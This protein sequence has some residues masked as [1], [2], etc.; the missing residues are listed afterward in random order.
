MGNVSGEKRNAF[1]FDEHTHTYYLGAEPLPSVTQVLSD[2]IPSWK[3]GEWYLQRGRAVHACAALIV[4]GKDFESDP[5]IAGYIQAC[6]EW[7]RVCQPTECRTEVRLFHP[8]HRYAGT[9]DLFCKLGGKKCVIDWKS[10]I[11]GAV[12]YQLAAYAFIEGVRWGAAVRL[13][14]DGHYS[15]SFM[16]DLSRYTQGWLGLLTAY[17]IRRDMMVAEKEAENGE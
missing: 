2:L 12:P 15:M 16:W 7:Y 1:H 5:R 9:A 8:L 14:E 13:G 3:A 4:E 17:R 10:T 6:R 11:T